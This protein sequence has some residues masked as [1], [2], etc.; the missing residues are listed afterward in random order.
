M[1]AEKLIALGFEPETDFICR[2]D[3]AGAY[4]AEWLSADP[5]PS[6]AEIDAAKPRRK[7]LK[8]IVISR[9]TNAQLEAAITNM[10]NRQRERWRS[11]DSPTVWSDDQEVIDMIVAIGADPDVVLADPS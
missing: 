11:P 2:D 1:L 8:S 3:G 10:T 5:Q 9:L 6:Q 4:I 7:V